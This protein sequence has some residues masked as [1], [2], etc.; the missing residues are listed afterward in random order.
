MGHSA[1]SRDA[2]VFLMAQAARLGVADLVWER[3]RRGATAMRTAY[4]VLMQGRLKIAPT[5]VPNR[6]PNRTPHAHSR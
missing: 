4:V 2:V 6:A 3:I 5:Q 1:K